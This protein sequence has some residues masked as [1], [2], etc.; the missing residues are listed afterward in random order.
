MPGAPERLPGGSKIRSAGATPVALVGYICSMR[1]RGEGLRSDQAGFTLLELL[2]VMIIISILAAIAIPVFFRQ[3]DKG[4]VAQ[5]Q[6]ALANAK[7]TAEAYYT[8]DGDG[9][10]AGLQLPGTLEGEGLRK[11]DNVLL[12][13]G[14]TMDEYCITAIHVALPEEHSWKTA[15]VHSESGA[16]SDADGCTT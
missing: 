14:A 1:A 3:R 6:S 12:V 13:V 2:V 11:A 7:L 4:F 16:P 15:S 9:S 10:Y 8:G 5:S